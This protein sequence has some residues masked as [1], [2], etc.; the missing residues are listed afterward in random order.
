[1][2]HACPRDLLPHAERAGMACTL[3]HIVASLAEVVVAMG[4]WGEGEGGR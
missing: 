4:W 1:M 3:L 2:V